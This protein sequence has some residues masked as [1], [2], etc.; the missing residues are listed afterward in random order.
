MF[1][2]K[3]KKQW[4]ELDSKIVINS[5][6]KHQS[7]LWSLAFQIFSF[8]FDSWFNS[9]SYCN[10]WLLFSFSLLN[11]IW[12]FFFRIF[13]NSSISFCNNSYSSFIGLKYFMSFSI[14]PTTYWFFTWNCL[15]LSVYSKNSFIFFYLNLL[16]CSVVIFSHNYSK[17]NTNCFF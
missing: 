1:A 4:N 3:L 2:L 15:P 12:S 7:S 11:I 6:V 13:L 14:F 16:C 5:I 17:L 9:L 8:L 10:R